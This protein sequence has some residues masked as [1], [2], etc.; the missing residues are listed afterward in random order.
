MSDNETAPCQACGVLSDRDVRLYERKAS[1]GSRGPVMPGRFL[2]S[3]CPDCAPLGFDRPGAAVRA[4][5][6]LINKPETDDLVAFYAG[7]LADE[8][9]DATDAFFAGGAPNGK[10]FQH[11]SRDFRQELKRCFAIALMRRVE[12][13]TPFEPGPPPLDRG[14]E[15]AACLYCGRAE[16]V[17]WHG[18]ATLA[19]PGGGSV[20]GCLCGLC[21]SVMV[22]FSGFGWPSEANAFRVSQGLP[23]DQS[24][25]RLR[26]VTTWYRLTDEQKA[27]VT[28]PWSWVTPP[29]PKVVEPVE[30]TVE[31]LAAQVSSLQAELATLRGAQG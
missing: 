7:A 17:E 2:R 25:E 29:E 31:V 15:A 23:V 30:V 27:A 3:T 20:R 18:F 21:S 24:V 19:T 4:C 8:G 5:L 22:Q 6:R 16:D 1:I 28:G 26:Y 10:P 11:V 13:N 14:H 9:V 12:A